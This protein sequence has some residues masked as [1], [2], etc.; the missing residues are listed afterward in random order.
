[1]K[2]NVCTQYKHSP[3]W[4]NFTKSLNLPT[5]LDVQGKTSL[6]LRTKEKTGLTTIRN[7]RNQH[8]NPTC[9]EVVDKGYSDATL[10]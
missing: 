7:K 3:S 1:M 5:Y 4:V 9:M 10:G 6:T 2:N 8:L